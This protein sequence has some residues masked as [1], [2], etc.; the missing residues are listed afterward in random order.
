MGQVS[1]SP[2]SPSLLSRPLELSL[3]EGP[4]FTVTVHGPDA[5]QA[6]AAI[7]ALI[8]EP[9]LCGEEHPSV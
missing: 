8:G 3:S 4:P 1:P 7:A 9:A 2:I 5:E 6:L